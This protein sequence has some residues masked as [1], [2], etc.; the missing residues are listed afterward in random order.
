MNLISK[1]QSKK[2]LTHLVFWV[3]VFLFYQYFFAYSTNNG[4]D[5][6]WF[7]M[8]LLPLSML[9]TYFFI[10]FLIP[11]YL[12]Q[13]RYFKFGLYSLYTFLISV[14]FIGL[15][16][17][18]YYLLWVPLNPDGMPFMSR[19]F[20]YVIILMYLVVM[21]VSFVKILSENFTKEAK[22]RELK[23]KI[24]EAD[25]QLKK[26]ELDYLKK[27]IHPHFLFNS[28]NTIYGLALIKDEA[29]PDVIIKLSNL[30]DYILYQV[31]KPLVSLQNEV[32]HIEEYI[33]LEGFRFKDTLD[34]ELNRGEISENVQIA[35]MLLIP[36]VENA[37]KHGKIVGNRLKVKIDIGMQKGSLFLKVENSW[38]GDKEALQSSGIGLT[39][40]RKRLDLLYPDTY[41]LEVVPGIENFKIELIVNNLVVHG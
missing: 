20:V 23:N 12:L 27:Q 37:F 30:L 19:Q 2:L 24:L 25:L 14:D 10:Y 34:V 15:T 41:E 29:T 32:N 31:G 22:N 28:L 6:P 33:A 35:P 36:F 11:E 17:A 4:I 1:I 9:V 21:S 3:L 18:F 5:G 38:N 13:K 39:N 8:M 26:Q 40:I 7:A 16:V